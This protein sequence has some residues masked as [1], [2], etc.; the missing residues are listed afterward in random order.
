AL[1][2]TGGLAK[3]SRAPSPSFEPAM[4]K[5]LDV[6]NAWDESTYRSLLRPGHGGVFGTPE[7]LLQ[8]EKEEL[9]CYKK[10]HGVCKGFSPIEAPSPRDATFKMDC[11]RGPFEMKVTLSLDGKFIDG[12]VGISRDASIPKDLRAV[13]ERL[14]GLVRRWD[15]AVYKKHL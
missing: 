8:L 4:K 3:R 15:D 11:E 10:L 1:R 12:F 13:A 6:Y 5:L 2:K 7:D 9:A 14:A